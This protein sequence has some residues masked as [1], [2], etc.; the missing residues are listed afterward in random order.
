VKVLFLSEYFPRSEDGDIT[1]GTE[2]VAYYISRHLRTKHEVVVLHGPGKGVAWSDASL[3]SLPNRLR[4]VFASTFRGAR[5]R[6]DVVI[7][8][9]FVGYAAAWFV[10][11]FS[12]AKV[13]FWYNDVLIGRWTKGGFGRV[14][15][16]IGEIVERALLRLPSVHYIAISKITESRL[17]EHGINP[18]RIDV[19][20]C[21][22]EPS[23]IAQVRQ[24]P[25]DR[26]VIVVVGRLVPYKNVDVVVTAFRQV[27]A[28]FPNSELKIIGQGPELE[29]LQA[30]AKRLGI[31]KHVRFLGFVPSHAKV[32]TEIGSSSVLVSASSVEGFGIILVEAMAL[33]IPLVVSDI[34]ASLEVTD[35]SAA[36][37]IPLR[38]VEA[39]S[40]AL[41]SLFENEEEAANLTRKGLERAKVFEWPHLADQTANVL[42]SLPQRSPR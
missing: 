9:T 28:R 24:V 1:G 2:A 7:G 3:R 36:I 12:Q 14:A 37:V 23:L 29:N 10:G 5:L 17:I 4:F 18:R 16:L 21:G 19:V 42:E 34:P 33:G 8:T 25:P 15:G 41:T 11:L 35:R 39:L 13:V 26:P 32:L 31:S 30:M 6:P 27:L 40:Q 38:D 20:H 22:V